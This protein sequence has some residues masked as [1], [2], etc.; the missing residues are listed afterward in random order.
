VRA[1][2]I[3]EQ[4]FEAFGC[5]GQAARIKPVPLEKMAARYPA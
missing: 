3:C 2:G 5:A 1:R 4:R